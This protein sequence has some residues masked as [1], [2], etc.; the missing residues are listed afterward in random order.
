MTDSPSRDRLETELLD[1]DQRLIQ[2]RRDR[3]EEDYRGWCEASYGMV[4]V[5]PEVFH[6]ADVLELA[7]DAARRGRSD[8]AAQMRTDL[9]QIVC[10]QFPAPIA[11]PFFGFVEGPRSPLT[12][13]HRLRDAWES[14]VRLL[15]AIALSEAARIGPSMAPICLRESQQQGTREGK[16][17]DLRSDKLSI[18]I[19]LIEGVLVRAKELS[20][21]LELSSLLPM[22]V[23]AEIRRLN[24]VR[25]EFSHESTK[26]ERQAQ[27]II[28][29][30]YPVL[31]EV[32]LDLREMQ[33]ID[34]IRIKRVIP[35]GIAEVER[36]VGHAQSQRIREIALDKDAA[37]L[38][39]SASPVDGMDRV[40]AQLGSLTLDLSP[41]LYAADDDTGH[42]TRVFVFKCQR[43]AEWFLECVADSTSRSSPAG[44]HEALLGRF[45][46]LIGST[47]GQP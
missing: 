4:E 23:L 15:A 39:L 43:S 35:G 8:A 3:D 6:P 21:K 25:N 29:E 17:R 45:E 34:L 36:L 30:A 44:L 37:S 12:R 42:R 1:P 20:I 10:E 2:R 7:P 22:D 11:V 27:E 13:V 28:D 31:R 41:F 14:L 18:R 16:R 32:M 47:G 24:V 5:G 46:D 19:G 9:E 26:S 40:F 33:S 38:A